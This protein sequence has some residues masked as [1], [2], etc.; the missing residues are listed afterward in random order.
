MVVICVLG[1]IV[2]VQSQQEGALYDLPGANVPAYVSNTLALS[3][4]GRTL[5]AVNM[6]SDSMSIIAITNGEVTAEVPVGDDPRSIALT[7]DNTRAIV[8][9]RM[10]GTLSV[11]DIAEQTVIA[12]FSVGLLPYAVLAPT[13]NS[14]FVSLQGEDAVVEI[15]L[16]TGAVLR[17]IPTPDAPTGLASWG[18]FLYVTHLWSGDVSLV[19]LPQSQ[20][21]RTVSTGSDTGL[22][23]GLALDRSNGLAYV[24]QTRFN[25]Q[26]VALTYDSIVFP[27]VNVLDLSDLG[28]ENGNRI[29]LDTADRPVNMPF[30]TRV[31]PIRNW[32]FVANAGSNDV[33]VIDLS[34]G[35]LLGH[36][37]VGANPRGLL[38]SINGGLLYAHNAIDGTVT[39][40]ETG[41]LTV[42]DV[43]PITDIT[44]PVDLL[45]GAELFYTATD[46]RL[47]TNNWI[48]CATCHFDGQSDGRNWVGFDGGIRNT[49]LLYD[50]FATSPYTWSGMWDELADVELKVRELQVG[51]GLI[52]GNVNEPLGA[53]H[54]GLSIDLDS[55][56]AY[57]LTLEPPPSSPFLTDSDQVGQGAELF[58]SLDCTGCH[59]GDA[60]TD[61]ALHD[62]GTGGT[63]NTPDLRWLW[64]SAP[65]FHDG[66][67]ETLYDVF[68]LAGDHQLVGDVA[69]QDIDALVAY[70]LTLPNNISE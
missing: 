55:L 25:A 37:E 45:I 34:N 66:R 8:T 59:I 31:D 68:T 17:S 70:L 23:Q 36:I 11:V 47:T 5:V 48:S 20:V 51:L 33:S 19:Y 50:L 1:T 65:Y 30:A 52:N 54:T 57:L 16:T 61:G 27:V 6:L 38:L 3:N 18:E 56:T 41:S 46:E 62:V 39:T 35:A 40:I 15:D 44:I 42:S 12:N 60:F 69:Q 28:L 10:S 32:L 64:Q 67:A 29:T 14:A 43:L 9:N 63:F 4:N 53:M 26:N 2:I 49:P 58:Q 24:P 7:P 22:S 13:N 21:V